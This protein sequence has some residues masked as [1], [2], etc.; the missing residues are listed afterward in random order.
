MGAGGHGIAASGLALGT[1]ALGEH[2]MGPMGM[3][4]GSIPP[5]AGSIARSMQNSNARAAV[6]GLGEKLRQRSPLYEQRVAN[7]PYTVNQ[8]TAGIAAARAPAAMA[9]PRAEAEPGRPFYARGGK[10][11]KPTHEFLV[12]RLMALAEKAKKAEKKH[13]API[14][15]MPDDAVTMALAKAQGGDM[16]KERYEFVP[17]ADLSPPR[18]ITE[19]TQLHIDSVVEA[20]GHLM[21]TEGMSPDFWQKIAAV[22]HG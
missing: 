20:Y 14:L 7:A 19:A 17:R 5:V 3:V 9:P 1:A 11:K 15:N 16:N 21:M 12:T 4:A 2:L 8:D 13:T 22:V 6:E 18:P 10:V